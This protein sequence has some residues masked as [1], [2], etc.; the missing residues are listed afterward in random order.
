MVNRLHLD[1][2][3]TLP[4]KKVL[5]FAFH[6]SIHTHTSGRQATMQ[7]PGLAHSG[8]NWGSVSW[9]LW[10]V[11]RSSQPILW[12][13]D[14]L[15]YLLSHSSVMAVQ[16][17]GLDEGR[18][19]IE[20]IKQRKVS[21]SML[22]FNLK[23]LTAII[24][25][26]FTAWFLKWRYNYWLTSLAMLYVIPPLSLLCSLSA[27]S[28]NAVFCDKGKNAKNHKNYGVCSGLSGKLS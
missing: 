13:V 15:F 1:T 12:L 11:D 20:Q 23:K 5:Q 9:K 7:V 16:L 8:A 22:P 19:L 27:S 28:Q 21:E 24:W 14:D 26:H 3:S 18:C 10:H 6:W 25:K 4:D 2:T 17:I